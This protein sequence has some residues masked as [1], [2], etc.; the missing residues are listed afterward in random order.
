MEHREKLKIKGEASYVSFFQPNWI[1]VVSNVIVSVF[2][3]RFSEQ[4]Q[5]LGELNIREYAWRAPH[6]SQFNQ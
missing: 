5:L 4:K 2:A 3:C 6:V 1:F